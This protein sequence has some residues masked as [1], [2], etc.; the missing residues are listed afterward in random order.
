MI[1][2]IVAGLL[3]LAMVLAWVV[4][5]SGARHAPAPELTEQET[6]PAGSLGQVA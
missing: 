4:L 2:T 6:I 1:L 5:P 3:F